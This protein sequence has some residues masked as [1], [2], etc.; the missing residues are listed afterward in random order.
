M[1]LLLLS[2]NARGEDITSAWNKTQFLEMYEKKIRVK[3]H[4]YFNEMM[5][6]MAITG[7]C[8]TYVV[9]WTRK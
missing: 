5:G 1:Y 7:C 6:Q 9:V 8:Q 4:K 2:I 3:T